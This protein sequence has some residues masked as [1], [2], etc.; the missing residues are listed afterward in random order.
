MIAWLIGTQPNLTKTP[1]S[2]TVRSTPSPSS[3]QYCQRQK[4]ALFERKNPFLLLANQAKVS[5][6]LMPL[7][8]V[9]YKQ[10]ARQEQLLFSFKDCD[11]RV[12]K[13]AVKVSFHD[14]DGSGKKQANFTPSERESRFYEHFKTKKNFFKHTL[15][16]C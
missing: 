12:E 13:M 7:N 1:S 5:D 11:A 3:V 4:Q 16:S 8:F 9:K 14:R 10:Y 6:L 2:Y 15:Q